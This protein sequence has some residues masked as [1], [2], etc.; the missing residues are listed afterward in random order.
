MDRSAK[1]VLAVALLMIGTG[2]F[3]AAKAWVNRNPGWI[4]GNSAMPPSSKTASAK[5]GEI[6]TGSGSIDTS[7][8]GAPI[9]PGASQGKAGSLALAAG[10]GAEPENIS[11]ATF[12]TPDSFDKVLNFYKD[13]LG[14][15]AKILQYNSEGEH[16][17]IVDTTSPDHTNMIGI[18]ISRKDEGNTT[19]ISMVS[20]SA[21]RTSQP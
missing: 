16:H 6:I 10:T 9:Y 4:L 5:P 15:D 18:R 21:P 17:A 2:V 20:S 1:V 8:L 13:K 12:T 3:L 7:K 19:E 11:G 14:P